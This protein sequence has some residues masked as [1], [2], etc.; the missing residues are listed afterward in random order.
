MNNELIKQAE[1]LAIEPYTTEVMCDET[2]TGED[3][4]LLSHPE[5]H[6]CMAQGKTIEEATTNLVDAT[7]EYILSLLEDGLPVPSPT[8]KM[9]VTAV[10]QNET[11]SGEYVSH[12]DRTYFDDLTSVVQP[13]KRSY[14]GAASLVETI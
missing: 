1:I 10:G 3:I 13:K 12:P 14:L 6:G 8:Y 2:T 4:Y 9:T 5:L 11:Y 7:K